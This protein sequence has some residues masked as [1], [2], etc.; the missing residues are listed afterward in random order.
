[1]K[2]KMTQSFYK[3]EKTK[4]VK[5]ISINAEIESF[6]M[7][8]QRGLNAIRYI[9]CGKAR[10]KIIEL[11]NEY[12]AKNIYTSFELV[13]TDDNDKAIYNFNIKEMF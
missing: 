13:I 1:M 10:G 8:T 2:I 5:T 9:E 3:S 11:P 4:E 6:S 12:Q 7:I